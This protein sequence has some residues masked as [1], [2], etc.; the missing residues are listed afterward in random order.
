MRQHYKICRIA[1]GEADIYV[2]MSGINDWDLAAGHAIV[3]AAG[4]NVIDVNGNQLLYNT[5]GQ[6]LN[7]FIIYGKTDLGWTDFVGGTDAN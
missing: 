7:P 4:G 2:R 5:E 6:R 3:E 1:E